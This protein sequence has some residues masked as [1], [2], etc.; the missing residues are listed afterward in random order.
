[1]VSLRWPGPYRAAVL[2]A[3]A[4]ALGLM[5][6]AT[7]LAANYPEPVEGEYVVS[8]FRFSS[9]EILP[10]LKLHYTT[11]GTAARDA[12][13]RVRNAVLLLHG[14]TGKGANFLRSEWADT[15]FGPGQPLDA[16]RYFI[17]LPDSI[18]NGK[19]SKPSN[20]LRTRF[21]RYT[22]DDMVLSQYRLLTEKLGVDH[23]RL[24]VGT[25][26]GGMHA[27]MWGVRYPEFMDALLPMVCTPAQISGRNR[28]QRKLMIDAI[29]SDPEWNGGDYSHPPQ[30]L[31]TALKMSVISAGSARQLYTEGSTTEAADRV[32][33]STV[34]KQLAETDA[35]DFL[36]AWEASRGYD[37]SPGLGRIRALVYAINFGDDDRNPPELGVM[38][39]EIARVPRG[40][41]I[42][43]P[44]GD[45]TRGH[46]SFYRT[47]LWVEYLI[48][49]L[50]ASEVR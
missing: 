44:G 15:L 50:A 1:M 3:G 6:M 11:I 27:W 31:A 29:R 7:G 16:T 30:G 17:V 36:Y 18:G 4:L 41:Y 19:S 22:Y 10:E 45:Q 37:P 26:M 32:L 12:S 5:T 38:E 48:E 35:N 23:V 34:A 14:T 46:V 8:D 24:I 47:S 9:G 39:R 13:G 25:S 20:G 33:D 21:P 42:L 43:V 40:R 49:L 2:R 28:M